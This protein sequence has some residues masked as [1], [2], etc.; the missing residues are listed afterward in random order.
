M[1]LFP[2][3][4]SRNWPVKLGLTSFAQEKSEKYFIWT[5]IF[6]R[7]KFN[8]AL[9]NPAQGFVVVDFSFTQDRRRE[10]LDCRPRPAA[11]ALLSPLHYFKSVREFS[12]PQETQNSHWSILFW[13]ELSITLHNPSK[14]LVVEN[15]VAIKKKQKIMT[16]FQ[17]RSNKKFFSEWTR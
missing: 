15:Y 13:K 9:K 8:P 2:T 14:A 3:F 16:N 10:R 1:V 4:E 5:V 11:P 7:V 12:L 17:W 6:S